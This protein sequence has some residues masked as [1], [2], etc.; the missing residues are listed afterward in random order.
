MGD[1]VAVPD[2]LLQDEDLMTGRPQERI[3][4][5]NFVVERVLIS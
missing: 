2:R 5:F 4:D 1:D 3:L